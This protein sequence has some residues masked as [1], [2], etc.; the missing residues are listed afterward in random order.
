MD[1]ALTPPEA[2]GAEELLRIDVACYQLP[3]KPNFQWQIMRQFLY[4][5]VREHCIE[6]V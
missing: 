5:I 2:D 4:M 1:M 6:G 3:Q